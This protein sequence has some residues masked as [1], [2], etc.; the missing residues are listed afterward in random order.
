MTLTNIQIR[1]RAKRKKNRIKMLYGLPTPQ[2]TKPR[3]YEPKG[4]PIFKPAPIPRPD[5][6]HLFEVLNLRWLP[7]WRRRERPESKQ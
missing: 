5:L 6:S 2:G 3:A 7:W 1:E 4:E